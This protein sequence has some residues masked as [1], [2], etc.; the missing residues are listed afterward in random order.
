M[1]KNEI[2]QAFTQMSDWICRARRQCQEM[3]Q[4]PEIILLELFSSQEKDAC[5]EKM[6]TMLHEFG[7]SR[8]SLQK[9]LER[10][11]HHC[12]RQWDCDIS[13]KLTCEQQYPSSFM[14]VYEDHPI[15]VFNVYEKTFADRRNRES[16]ETYEARV[17]EIEGEWKA[18]R[19]NLQ[20]LQNLRKNP[21][22][23]LRYL[24]GPWW[25]RTKNWITGLWHLAV[26]KQLI[27]EALAY[28]IQKVEKLMEDKKQEFFL[29]KKQQEAAMARQPK[30][31]EKFEFWRER[32]LA[33]G[34]AET[35]CGANEH[36]C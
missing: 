11:L 18:L 33:W 8:H 14:I 12:L 7:L 26:R 36:F 22:E 17:S 3:Y 34:Y 9:E 27:D 20:S 28:R 24:D 4:N 35:E 31:Q 25:I 19:R 30:E 23:L 16:I 5:G 6:M 2:D 1:L 10:L 15:L 29:L 21:R 32:F 13:V